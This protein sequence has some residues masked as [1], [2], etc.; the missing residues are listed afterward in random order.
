MYGQFFKLSLTGF[1]SKFYF[2]YT[3]RMTKAKEP[4]LA[5]YESNCS[6]SSCGYGGK[7]VGFIIF[8]RILALLEM[9]I[10]SS[11]IWTQM[12]VSISNNNNHYSMNTMCE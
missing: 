5:Y 6:P 1:N 9:Q 12:S 8:P 3:G 10:A 4:S 2:S 11:K 7:I